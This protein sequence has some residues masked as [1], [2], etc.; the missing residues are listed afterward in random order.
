M[1][2]KH[3][4]AARKIIANFELERSNDVPVIISVVVSC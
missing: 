2:F 4:V 1:E 3:A